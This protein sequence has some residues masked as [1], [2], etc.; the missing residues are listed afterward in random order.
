MNIKCAEP[1]NGYASCLETSG[2]EMRK[3][4]PEQQAFNDCAN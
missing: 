2:F 3:C 1:L 4:R